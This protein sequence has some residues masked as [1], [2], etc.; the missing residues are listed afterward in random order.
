MPSRI[1]VMQVKLEKG[2]N[3]ICGLISG[4]DM[5]FF[6]LQAVMVIG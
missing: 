1:Q 4:G 5:I 2:G 3:A 6:G